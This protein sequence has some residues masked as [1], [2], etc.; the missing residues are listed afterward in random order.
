MDKKVQ[1]E[2]VLAIIAPELHT[3]VEEHAALSELMD[4]VREGYNEEVY[5]DALREIGEELTQHFVYEEEF[6]LPRLQKHIPSDTAGPV[7]KLT[8]EHDVIR[9]SYEEVRQMFLERNPGE[10]NPELMKKMNLLAY[11]LKKHIEKEDHYLF[12]MASVILTAE[13]RT[14]IADEIARAYALRGI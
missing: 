2:D 7:M 13:E 12:P 14:E 5:A 9:N 10:P 6:I 1:Q 8:Q 3:Y 4:R 11:L